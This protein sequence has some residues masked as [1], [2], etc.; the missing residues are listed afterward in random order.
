MVVLNIKILISVCSIHFFKNINCQPYFSGVLQEIRY[1]HCQLW[2]NNSNKVSPLPSL[3]CFNL[4][5][6]KKKNFSIFTGQPKYEINDYLHNMIS[7]KMWCNF[8]LS[9]VVYVSMN[10]GKTGEW[11][12]LSLCFQQG[13]DLMFIEPLS[14]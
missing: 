6:L 14:T 8:Q 9:R 13:L 4:C 10:E 12:V 1:A 2:N 7:S 5:E 11:T 3:W